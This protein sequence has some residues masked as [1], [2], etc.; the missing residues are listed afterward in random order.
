MDA[1]AELARNFLAPDTERPARNAALTELLTQYAAGHR[2]DAETGTW[3]LSSDGQEVLALLVHLLKEP[4][5]SCAR[6]AAQRA[7]SSESEELQADALAEVLMPRD[8]APARICSWRPE[9]GSLPVWLRTVFTNLLR[10]RHRRRVKYE[11]FPGSADA[12]AD[13]CPGPET[14][15]SG[16]DEPFDGP[17]SP[18]DLQEVT[19]WPPQVRIELLCLAGLSHKVPASLWEEWL[20]ALERERQR[21]LPRPFPP[22]AFLTID[23]REQ[24]VRPLAALFGCAVNTL[25]QRWGRHRYRFEKLAFVRN[26]QPA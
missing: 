16:W 2:Q 25:S 21:P 4:I 17:F 22:P 15:C 5:E 3:S 8:G 19:G 6:R 14:L 20:G 23:D 26:L 13:N 18:A 1:R 12:E 7:G 11:P 24:R 9:H 10:D